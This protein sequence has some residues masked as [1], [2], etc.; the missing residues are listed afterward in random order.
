MM[1][2]LTD[3]SLYNH[4]IRIDGAMAVPGSVDRLHPE[5]VLCPG[6]QAV[7]R[8]PKHR[9]GDKNKTKQKCYESHISFH[10]V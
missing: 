5:H 1:R 8:K 7:A 10:S 2:I 6:G 4:R 3:G 9:E